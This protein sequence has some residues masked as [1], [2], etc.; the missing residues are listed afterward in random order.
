MLSSYPENLD[1]EDRLYMQTPKRVA[2]N[3]IRIV[4][5]KQYTNKYSA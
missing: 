1:I 2:F 4:K 3:A 5:E